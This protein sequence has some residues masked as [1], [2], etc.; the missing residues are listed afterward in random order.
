MP[1][2]TAQELPQAE[3]RKDSGDFSMKE[4]IEI[5]DLYIVQYQ[6]DAKIRD[7]LVGLKNHLASLS[8]EA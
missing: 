7:V 2:R 6:S 4:I 3:S 5:V 8:R 1:K